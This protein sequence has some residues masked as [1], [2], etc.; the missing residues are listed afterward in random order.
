MKRTK[1]RGAARLTAAVVRSAALGLAV[2]AVLAGPVA[3]AAQ[4]AGAGEA[5][6]GERLLEAGRLQEAGWA[7]RAAGDTAR[8][9]EVL[10]RLAGILRAWPVAAQPLSMDSQGVSYTWRLD[11]GQ[12]VASIFKVDG[13]D[14]FCPACGADRE[15][16]SYR[17]D[18]L[19]DFDLTPMT[20]FARIAG[21]QGDTLAGSAMYFVAGG[22]SPGDEGVT[23]PDALRFF[24]AVIGNSDRHPDNW[25]LAGDR[26][27]AIDHNRAFE[28]QPT[29]RPTTCWETEI[30]SIA[31]PAELG[32]PWRR[33][34]GLPADS[35]RAALA[36][37][38]TA[39][40][41]RF[42][43]MR[44]RVVGRIEARIADPGRAL[45]LD[46]CAPRP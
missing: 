17:L 34:R 1:V 23:K 4:Q 44:L 27:V 37:I 15:V 40:V 20:V 5:G 26:V 8:A 7:F 14:I 24:D 12:G 13:S 45:P 3:V 25:L 29:T 36:G 43:D 46:D 38:D 30:D 41:R 19:L 33:Y 39:L 28:W 35:V 16:A 42:L 11:H 9:A 6:A 32:R 31:A 18:A 10:A 22:R 2:C 21:S